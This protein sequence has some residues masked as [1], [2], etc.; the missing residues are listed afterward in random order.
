MSLKHRP[1]VTLVTHDADTFLCDIL[2]TN[3]HDF[4]FVA[5]A[6]FRSFTTSLP[7]LRATMALNENVE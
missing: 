1:I 2:N 7:Q 5:V 6:L 4:S 3:L